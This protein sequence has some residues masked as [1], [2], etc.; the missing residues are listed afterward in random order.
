MD[1]DADCRDTEMMSGTISK[2]LRMAKPCRGVRKAAPFYRQF[3]KG[4]NTRE[5]HKIRDAE[6]LNCWVSMPNHTVVIS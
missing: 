5:E 6:C 3:Y 4:T 1:R 2:E